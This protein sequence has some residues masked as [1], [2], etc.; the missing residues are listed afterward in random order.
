MADMMRMYGMGVPDKEKMTLSIN[1]N[2]KLIRSLS[3]KD[4]ETVKAMAKEIYFLSLLG[5]RSLDKDELNTLLY[6]SYSIL[7]KAVGDK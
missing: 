2:S 7:E 4:S 5:K 6:H 1:S 3:D